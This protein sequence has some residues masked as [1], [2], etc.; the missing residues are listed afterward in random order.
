MPSD[1]NRLI[2]LSS[3]PVSQS[4]ILRPSSQGVGLSTLLTGGNPLSGIATSTLLG[5][6]TSSDEPPKWIHVTRR[7]EAFIK[8]L[9]LTNGQVEDGERK[10]KG[11]VSCLNYA[12]YGNSSNVLNAFYTGSWAK[13]TR[14]RPPRDADL[15]FVLPTE[16]FWR[17]EK[18]IGS[19]KQSALLQ[20]VKAVL[21]YRYQ[22]SDIKGDGPI[23]LADFDSYC[24]EIVPAFALSD[25]DRGY[26]ICDTK[27]GGRYVIAQPLHEI[28]A[29]NAADER[30]NGNVRRLIHML[31]AW[32]LSCSVPIKSFFL[33]LLAIEFM[34][35]CLWRLNSYFYYDWISRDFFQWMVTK[36]NSNLYAPGTSK[37]L[38]L[39]DAWKS[40][41]ES[42]YARCLKACDY[43]Q[44][45][46]EWAAG[47]EWQKIF[48]LDIPKWVY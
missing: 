24:V 34:D 48:G 23:V 1:Q 30:N 46:N 20:E 27:H 3:V 44:D 8:A 19:N 36:A 21:A 26:F 17:F 14:I 18:N 10:Y 6:L 7:F 29:I 31:K 45:N 43:E 33:E 13:G 12:Y 32:Q 9:E 39:G 15:Y 16:V 41:C 38:F 25:V 5:G 40:R 2:G 11:V 4:G 28:D 47:E 35:Q 37:T 22:R 42:A